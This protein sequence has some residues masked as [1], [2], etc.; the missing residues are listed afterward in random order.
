MAETPIIVEPPRERPTFGAWVG[1]VLLFG[2]FALLAWAVIGAM[3]RSDSYERE[4]AKAR[5][6]KLKT[7]HEEKAGALTRY[8]WADKEKGV[9]RIPIERAMALTIAELAQKK[10]TAAAPINPAGTQP[11]LQATVPTQ[12]AA[13]PS[14]PPGVPSPSPDITSIKGPGSA[15][16]GQPAAAANPPGAPPN[17]QPGPA[18]TPAASPGAPAAQVPVPPGERGST[19]SNAAPKAPL[20]VRGASP[21]P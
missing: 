20:P 9:V 17:T 14:P 4:R 18:S 6:E 11:G 19:P 16:E 8:E 7:Y 12:P 5:L 21:S 10:P 13:V 3:P 1:I 2:I 15:I